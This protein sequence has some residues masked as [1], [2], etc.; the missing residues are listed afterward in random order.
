MHLEPKRRGGSKSPAVDR[1]LPFLVTTPQKVVSP[2][3]RRPFDMG[4]SE[5][6]TELAVARREGSLHEPNCRP[7][8][9]DGLLH[10][11]SSK[12][13]K[14]NS[15][16]APCSIYK[17]CILTQQP[18][19]AAVECQAF[20]DFFYLRSWRRTSVPSLKQGAFKASLPRLPCIRLDRHSPSRASESLLKPAP[21]Q[22]GGRQWPR[23]LSGTLSRRPR[24]PRSRPPTGSAWKEAMHDQAA[25]QA[26]NS[27][28]GFADVFL[29]TMQP[30]KNNYKDPPA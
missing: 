2:P 24:E 14:G 21:A 28:M 5:I 16:V 27:E 26:L 18:A 7:S 30:N 12:E 9:N 20:L 25:F 29:P 1:C 8:C 23:A 22:D 17:Q 15:A 11:A 3:D 6:S 10:L 19:R 4:M 13:G